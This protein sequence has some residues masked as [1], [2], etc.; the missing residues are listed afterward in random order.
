MGTTWDITTQK[1]NEAQDAPLR[2]YD[3]EWPE[4][5]DARTKLYNEETPFQ[6]GSKNRAI[7]PF[8]PFSRQYRASIAPFYPQ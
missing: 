7:A 2:K 1:R 8:A 5:A 6:V 4:L 3:A